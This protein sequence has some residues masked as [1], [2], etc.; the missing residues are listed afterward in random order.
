[1]SSFHRTICLGSVD[2]L[3][4]AVQHETYLHII[5]NY[6]LDTA[7]LEVLSKTPDGYAIPTPTCDV[8]DEDIRS[9]RLHSDAVISPFAV[10]SDTVIMQG[11]TRYLDR[12][13]S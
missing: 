7:V 6:I 4:Q 3:R 13:S 10:I 5:H 1:M 8:L 12:Q 11:K 9:S 2:A